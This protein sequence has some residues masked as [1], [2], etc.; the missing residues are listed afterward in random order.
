[1]PAAP[2]WRSCTLRPPPR[3]SANT[4][5][6]LIL[7]GADVP[8]SCTRLPWSWQ[9]CPWRRRMSSLLDEGAL[10]A[11]ADDGREGAGTSVGAA[12]ERGRWMMPSSRRWTTPPPPS[13]RRLPSPP[14]CA[15]LLSVAGFRPDW[16]LLTPPRGEVVVKGTAG[17]DRELA[18][19]SAVVEVATPLGLLLTTGPGCGAAATRCLTPSG[20]GA[21]AVPP[22]L[23]SPLLGGCP[24]SSIKC[25]QLLGS[26]PSLDSG[27]RCGS[28]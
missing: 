27:V 19:S 4:S 3:S 20:G 21:N 9:R 18:T 26:A 5:S 25:G 6:L 28:R 1:M 16:W 15:S 8:P 17:N 14:C 2:R 22:P 24:F 13:R 23:F 10:P 11:P 7:L 12:R